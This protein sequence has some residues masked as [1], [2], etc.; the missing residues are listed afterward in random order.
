MTDID[1]L[2]RTAYETGID[3][4]AY[5]TVNVIEAHIVAYLAR[6]EPVRLCDDDLTR[7][8]ALACRIAGD[9]M[10]AGWTAPQIDP[11]PEVSP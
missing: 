2:A 11:E 4:V 5:A 8:P 10:A 6:C 1:L 9:L 3:P 7:I